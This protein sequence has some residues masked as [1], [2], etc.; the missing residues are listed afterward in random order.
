[1][2]VIKQ[3]RSQ[4]IWELVFKPPRSL[5]EPLL[6]PAP[7]P[8]GTL[9]DYGFESY[10]GLPEN[11]MDAPPDLHSQMEQRLHLGGK[12]CARGL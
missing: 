7:M 4:V 10:L 2:R 8:A 11:C 9:D 12:P 3:F 6:T 5:P 1:M